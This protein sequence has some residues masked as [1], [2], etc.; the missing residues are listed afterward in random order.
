LFLLVPAAILLLI[1]VLLLLLILL[2]LVLLILFV[3]V[4]LVLIF[5]TR[6]RRFLFVFEK[7]RHFPELWIL[8]EFRQ[9]CCNFCLGPFVIAENVFLRPA[10]DVVGRGIGERAKRQRQKTKT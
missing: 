9:A 1:F 5:F 2:V 7:L 3:F 8:R 6:R 4:L 10:I